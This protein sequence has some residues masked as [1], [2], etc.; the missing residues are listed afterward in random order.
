MVLCTDDVPDFLSPRQ[1]KNDPIVICAK[2][3]YGKVMTWLQFILPN[4]WG[5]FCIFQRDVHNIIWENDQNVN[6]CIKQ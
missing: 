3:L 5:A 2:I 4:L 1:K 6:N